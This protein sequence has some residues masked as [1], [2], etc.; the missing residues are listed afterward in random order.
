MTLEQFLKEADVPSQRR[1]ISQPQHVK[2]LKY[3]MWIRNSKLPG[4]KEAE[5]EITKLF[6]SMFKLS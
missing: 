4:F 3:N 5:A 1:D 6:N 2:W